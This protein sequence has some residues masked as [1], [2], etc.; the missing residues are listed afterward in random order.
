MLRW[1]IGTSLRFR[2]VVVGLAAAVVAL[3]VTQ[4]PKAPVDVLPEFTPP[5]S[6]IQTE[7][8]GLSAEEVEQFVTVP[9]EADLLNGV[10]GVDVIRSKSV[11]GL[12]SIV[13]VFEP[14]TDVFRARQLV[15]ERLTQAH[16]LPNVSK[17][18]TLLQ[19]LSSSSRLLL[20]GL[21][22]D[23]LSPI[24][25]S[26]IARWTIRPRL[27][28]VPGVANVA[29]W[30]L[31]DQQ[32]QVQVDPERLRER[33]VTLNQ[34]IRSTGNAQV[35]SPLSFL[36]ASTPGA[37]GFIETPSQRLQVR[38]VLDKLAEPEELGK[39]AVEGTGGRLRLTDVADVKVDHQ[40]LIGD[41]VV[42]D[43]DGLLL[44]VEKF[45]GA[46]AVEVTRG[47][48]EALDRLRPGLAG[49]RT[50]TSIFRPATFIEDAR[51]NLR[52]ALIIG[53][54]L[55]ALV[56]VALLRQWRTVLVCAVTIPLSLIAAAL[57]LDAFGE[58]FNA[59][60]LAGLAIALVIV[61]DEAVTGTENVVRR[62][63]AAREAGSGATTE[64]LV[65]DATREI[66]S[67][68][69]YATLIVLLA[70][71]PVAVM[72]GRPGAFF[73]P[74][75]LAYALGVAAAAVV[76]LCVTPALSLLL[77][78]RGS[79]TVG[80]SRAV[81]GAARGYTPGLAAALRRPRAVLVAAA[82]LVLVGLA[83]LPL[84]GTSLIP[85]FKDRD[86]LVR[87]DG[88]PGTSHPRMTAIATDVSRRLRALRGVANTGAH[89]GR[90]V[91]GDQAVDVN[92]SEV[93]VSI[94]SGADYG[95]TRA[96][97][98]D[99]VRGVPGVDSDVV[100]YSTQKIRD[101]GAL[102]EGRNDVRG[103][104]LDVL[105][106]V[107]APL[108]VR[109]Y[110]Q[111]PARLRQEAAK[112]RRAIAQVDGV[113][114]PRIRQ[115]A[116][117]PSVEIEVDLARARSLGIKPGDVR[118]A[119]AT[120]L[121][122]IQVGSVFQLQKVFDV[123]VQGVPATRRSVAGVRDLLIDRPGGGHV[124]L[125]D[126]A[127]VRIAPA[128]VAIEREAVSRYVDVEAGVS[129]RST[130]AVSADVEDRLADLR[131][132]LEYHAEVVRA[133]T[134][135]EIG[136]TGMLAFLVAGLIAAVLLLQAAFQSWR[137]A[138]LAFAALP[139]ALVGGL[140]AALIDG[141][142]LSL[143]SLAGLLALFALAVR[144]G[145]VL[146]RRVQDL[147]SEDGQ[148]F[149]AGVVERGA[150]ER[151]GPVL[152]T[153]CA[154]VVLAVP[155]VVMGS[156]PGLEVVHPMAV[157]LLGGLVTSTF[158]SLFVLPALVL[159][160]GRGAGGPAAGDEDDLMRRWVGADAEPAPAGAGA[161]VDTGREATA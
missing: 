149:G 94:D 159:R 133:T 74:L 104:G 13:L 49:M 36:E 33:G 30:G 40:P 150:R 138:L 136:T 147:M 6:E 123:V 144:F 134:G 44:V 141:A 87:L 115:P 63:R 8:L 81:S 132:P 143:G 43:G 11:P 76:A 68:L 127:D 80:E 22:S 125:G 59:I 16:A 135:G 82:A 152:A 38:N 26:V 31:R 108:V 142:Q 67:P 98:E 146:I 51:H 24:E 130:A 161:G 121:Q 153:T 100:T 65:R 32:L 114:A 15:E 157:V 18:P 111:D 48:E 126:A 35:V 137:L 73:A 89:V 156:A 139:V 90:A 106:G 151:L 60:S 52:L 53:A 2:L 1:I 117:E 46:N 55:T 9:L 41:A 99:V 4:L 95:A 61:V 57:T 88:P 27:M 20:I 107:G 75:A 69:M 119:E 101:V 34:V 140:V 120:L 102:N 71:V 96:A 97:I 62:M 56:L 39:V 78:S 154:L 110:G 14:G 70:I 93:W 10:E 5:Y 158:L 118:R 129:G 160:F 103:D 148:A 58:G 128:P 79:P 122:G 47:V 155:V 21:S 28:G 37:G 50:D 54:A 45:P 124:R 23:R 112:V 3:G 72:Q 7:A 12:S 17:P 85:T 91:T 83:T 92:S 25:R 113:V 109:V 77:F 42:N 64:D 145:V 131:H 66:R 29:I 116:T 86:V 84:L 105:T 19:P